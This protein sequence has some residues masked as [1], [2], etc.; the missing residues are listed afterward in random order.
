MHLVFVP[1]ILWT[2]MV[3]CARPVPDFQVFGFHAQANW[4]IVAVYALYYLLLEPVAGAMIVPVL[5]AMAHSATVFSRSQGRQQANMIALGL[6][7]FSWLAQFAS[8]AWIERRRPALFDN[9]RQA[10]LLAPFF[11]WFEVLFACGYRPQLRARLE[12]DTLRAIRDKKK[13]K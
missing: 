6:H 11:V 1:L 3:W 5:M 7:V 13:S 12:L 4:L 9:L 2:V 10:L 8:H